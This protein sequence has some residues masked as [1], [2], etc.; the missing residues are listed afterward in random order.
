MISRI[1]TP[2]DQVEVLA[3]FVRFTEDLVEEL[4]AYRRELAE[5]LESPAFPASLRDDATM[6]GH[7]LRAAT[8]LAF[9]ELG[10]RAEKRLDRARL[11]AALRARGG[12]RCF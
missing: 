11:A 12:R 3:R 10:D 8:R 6:L 9:V 7:Y 2:D 5:I 1:P 4:L